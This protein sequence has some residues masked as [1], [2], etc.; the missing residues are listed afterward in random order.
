L[1][2]KKVLQQ[3]WPNSEVVCVE[4]GVKAL[5]ALLSQQFDLVLMDMVMPE[6][7][8]IE[9]TTFIRQQLEAPASQTPVLGLTANVNPQDLERFKGA[10]LNALMLKPF[11]P[12]QLYAQIEALI[13]ATESLTTKH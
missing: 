8:G 10:G 11:E 7:D 2:V 4:D 12:V 9:T 3:A 1:L 13:P 6:M 5:E